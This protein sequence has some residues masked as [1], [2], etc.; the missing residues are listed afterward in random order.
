M[1]SA[2][3]KTLC[4]PEC[5]SDLALVSFEEDAARSGLVKWGVLLCERCSVWYPVYAYAPVLLTF[6]TDLHRR[7]FD[8]F[9]NDIE[10]LGA[11]H[12]PAGKPQ[13]GE[14]SVQRSFTEEWDTVQSSDLSFLY[15][16]DDLK[17]LNERVWL[18]WLK[19]TDQPI[20][21]VLNIGAGLGRE[22][23]ALQRLMPDADVFA[24]DL[25][26]AVVA[27]AERLRMQRGLH[28][29]V[30]SLFKL[31]FKKRSFDLV[32]SQG[33]IHHTF[34]TRAALESISAHVAPDGFLFVWVYGL[35]DHLVLRGAV[36]AA[37]RILYTFEGVA[38]PAIARMPA[39]PRRL[40]FGALTLA[41]HPLIKA[42]VNNKA[43]WKLVNTNH[44]LRDWL[45][46][47]FAHRHSYNE[48]FEWFDALGFE[49]VDV[50]SPAEY[51]KLFNRRLWGVGLTGRL[52]ANREHAPRADARN[53]MVAIP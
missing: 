38:R 33:V 30:A 3:L 31:P 37:T 41:A 36:G 11:H 9:R 4:C 43:A 5:K 21:R 50:Q 26:L 17:A 14:E 42:R 24:V 13:R 34:S 2:I 44:D 12:A 22:S 40:L 45:S 15:T 35:D 51:R 46:P 1:D 28:I 23:L 7:F 19:K 27:A 32:Y 20:K 49:V 6:E 47:Q 53:G 39:F 8:R 29:I 10:A 18:S 16:D 48:L 25:N 52:R